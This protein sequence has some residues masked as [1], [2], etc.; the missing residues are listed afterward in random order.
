MDQVA[1]PVAFRAREDSRYSRLFW[2]SAAS[3][4]NLMLWA[5]LILLAARIA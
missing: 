3:A 5:G 4:F 1:R 2:L